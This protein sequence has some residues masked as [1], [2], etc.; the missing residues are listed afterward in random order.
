MVPASFTVL[1]A[2]P[3]TPSG[4]VDRRAL[5]EPDPAA[6]GEHVPPRTDTERALAAIWRE[7]LKVERVAATD[8]FF[9]LGGHSLLVTRLVSRL[10]A[11]LEVEVPLRVLYETPVLADQAAQV[12]VIRDAELDRVMAELEAM[13]DDEAR[14]ALAGEEAG[15]ADGHGRG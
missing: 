13:S 11:R 10:R 2:F 12:D 5:P 9:W 7:L 6:F 8:N 3:L 1:G 14:A 4:K 15:A